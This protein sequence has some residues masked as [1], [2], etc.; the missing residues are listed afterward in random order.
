M[1][2]RLAAGGV[3][4]LEGGGEIVLNYNSG[5]VSAFGFSGGHA[6]WNG[7]A[8]A[9]ASTGMVYGLNDSNSNYSDGF[10]T[11]G[12]GVGLGGFAAVSSGGSNGLMKDGP[13]AL[14]PNGQVV[15][16]GVSLGASL[17][18]GFAGG[19]STTDYSNP[20]QL[21]KFNGF[22]TLD[23]LFFVARQMLCK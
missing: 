15:V 19:V 23:M 20:R 14:L 8:S 13:G 10:T 7:G 3:G 12:G 18:G 6:G 17:A 9:T 21:G 2:F 4:G 16:L 11:F 5:Q 22:G 1:G